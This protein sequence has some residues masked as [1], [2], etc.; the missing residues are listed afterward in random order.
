LIVLAFGTP[1]YADT[2]AVC[3]RTPSASDVDAAKGMHKAAEQYYAKARYDKAITSWKEAYTFDCTAHRL[4]IN[5][6]NAYEKLGQTNE[7]IEAFDTYID[8]MGANADQTIVD[9]VANLRELA[10][11]RPHPVPQ[12]LP[13]PVPSPNPEPQPNDGG[14]S[15]EGPGAAPWVL[16]GV[17]AGVAVVGAVL[18]GVGVQKESAAD[19]ACPDRKCPDDDPDFESII[20]DGNLGLKMQVAGGVMLA[21]GLVA[22][23]GGVVWWVVASAPPSNSAALGES[24][25]GFNLGPLQEVQLLPVLDPTSHDAAMFGLGASG[26]F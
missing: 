7:A 3:D 17:G 9:K 26:R 4:L 12:P 23:A 22:A 14:D 10:A 19:E 6:G 16:V 1:A 21:V 24:P 18:L 13:T 11:T 20:D 25:M 5:I 15:G 2:Y 8:R